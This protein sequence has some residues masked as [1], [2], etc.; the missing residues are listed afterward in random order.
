[1]CHM[2]PHTDLVCNLCDFVVFSVFTLVLQNCSRGFR[3]H[4]GEDGAV[5]NGATTDR[6]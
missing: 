5:T 4:F 3:G 2:L 1:M 6:N